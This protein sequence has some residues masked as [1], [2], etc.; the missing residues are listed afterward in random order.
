M[1]LIRKVDPKV[2]TMFLFTYP[3]HQKRPS[4]E[5]YTYTQCGS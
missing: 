4:S 5:S 3:C 1:F 2:P